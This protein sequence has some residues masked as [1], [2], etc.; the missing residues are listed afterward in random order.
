MKLHELEHHW[1][2]ALTAQLGPGVRHDLEKGPLISTPPSPGPP[3]SLSTDIRVMSSGPDGSLVAHT[4][5]V[6]TGANPLAAALR[7]HK[8]TAQL[9]HR[10]GRTF[11]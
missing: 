9:H 5:L 1:G 4:P 7:G 2:E 11:I 3:C 8:V 10:G 6:S